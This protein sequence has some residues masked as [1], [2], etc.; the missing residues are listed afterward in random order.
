MVLEPLECSVLP[1]GL[2]SCLGVGLSDLC[3]SQIKVFL[4]LILF[5]TGGSVGRM[6]LGVRA[7][8]GQL[9]GSSPTRWEGTEREMQI[10][11]GERG[12]KTTMTFLLGGAL[13]LFALLRGRAGSCILRGKVPLRQAA[14][15]ALAC[16]WGTNPRGEQGDA[17][18]FWPGSSA[19]RGHWTSSRDRHCPQEW[20]NSTALMLLQPHPLCCSSP[21]WPFPTAS[22][23]L[24]ERISYFI[25]LHLLLLRRIFLITIC[26]VSSFNPPFV[27]TSSNAGDSMGIKGC[28]GE[29]RRFVSSPCPGVLCSAGQQPHQA[30]APVEEQCQGDNL[31]GNKRISHAAGRNL[32]QDF[33]I[34]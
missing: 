22:E 11:V 8:A 1:L 31:G 13:P 24:R 29:Q 18:W 16:D 12:E 25:P 14:E 3:S 5:A 21:K 27:V 34:L 4:L 6:Q 30:L 32:L 15:A 33:C 17:I 19:A 10:V 20:G 2:S 7:W 23:V 28:C 9:V 26:R